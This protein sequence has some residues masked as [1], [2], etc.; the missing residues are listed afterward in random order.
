MRALLIV[1]FL[2]L[3]VSGT[4]GQYWFGPKV[5][6][7]YIDHNYQNRNYEDTF[8]I[9][10][11]V[12][13]QVGAAFNYTATDMYSV[14]VEL[15]YEKIDKTVKDISTGG[16]EVRTSMT[17]HFI[18]IPAMLRVTL[19]KVP[20]HYFINGGPRLSYWVA[21]SGRQFLEEFIEQLPDPE[22]VDLATR[23]Y[24]VVFNRDN[25]EPNGNTAF[26]R[27]PNRVQFGLTVG[28]GI[29][30]DIQG[31][32]RLMLDARYTW[33]HSNMGA[34]S[35]SRDTNFDYENYRE[36]FEYSH[37]IASVGIA[38]LFGYDSDLRRKGRST[39]RES[40]KKKK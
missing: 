23:D 2:L 5:G 35:G 25:V 38:Y 12:N 11:D 40:N 31:G 39:N 15:M 8:D 6:V 1:S 37:N 21:G 24:K 30:F 28:G 33:V 10:K 3:T 4:F 9:A 18:T 29:F 27:K 22:R 34:N 16:D 26:I 32:G 7:S 14:Y 20:F 17:N 19:G 13:F 36:N